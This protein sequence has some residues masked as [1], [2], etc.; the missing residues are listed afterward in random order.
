MGKISYGVLKTDGGVD[1]IK[2]E[3][4]VKYSGSSNF[5]V[6]E[7]I[8]LI[9]AFRMT[10]DFSFGIGILKSHNKNKN[11]LISFMSRSGSYLWTSI[12]TVLK[13]QYFS[14]VAIQMGEMGLISSFWDIPRTNIEF[15]IMKIN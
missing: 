10:E 7:G 4:D 1:W 12:S 3:L 2:N 13:T 15:R 6:Q 5:I 9:Q 11:D 14:I 8:Y